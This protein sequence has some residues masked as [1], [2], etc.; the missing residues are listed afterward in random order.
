V[1]LG[2]AAFVLGV[3]EGEGVNAGGV[4][5]AEGVDALEGTE[6]VEG[7]KCL[8][9]ADAHDAATAK[10]REMKW[11]VGGQGRVAMA[12]AH[13]ADGAN[14]VCFEMLAEALVE[15]KERRL[16]GFHEETIVLVGGGE[17]FFELGDVEG[18]G[19]FAED[20]LAGGQGLDAE[21]GV[22]VRMGGDVDGVYVC[23]EELI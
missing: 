2:H 8:I 13:E 12:G 18:G 7:E 5:T 9:G 14:R 23:G 1:E 21:V 15:G 11:V 17:D 19:F 4:E 3:D 10:L 22:G 16:H 20:V 6:P